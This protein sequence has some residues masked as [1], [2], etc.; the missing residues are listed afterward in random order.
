MKEVEELEMLTQKLMKDME[1]PPPA[2]AA[3]SG[4]F[5]QWTAVGL[6]LL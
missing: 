3:T 2:E 1:H 6:R 5:P 4:A